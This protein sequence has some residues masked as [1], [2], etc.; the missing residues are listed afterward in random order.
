MITE[1][2]DLEI[3]INA[4]FARSSTEVT[5]LHNKVANRLQV[6]I[7]KLYSHYTKVGP[8]RDNLIVPA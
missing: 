7:L 8:L 4:L 6:S 1:F 5:L 3:R 2:R